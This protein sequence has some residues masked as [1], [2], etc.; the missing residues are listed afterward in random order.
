MTVALATSDQIGGAAEEI[1]TKDE[2]DDHEELRRCVRSAI[3]PD[4]RALGSRPS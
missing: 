1:E 4:V 3:F 2:E